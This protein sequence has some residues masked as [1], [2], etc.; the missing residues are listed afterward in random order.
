MSLNVSDFS[1]LFMQ[2]LDPQQKE[3]VR[4]VHYLRSIRIAWKINSTWKGHNKILAFHICIFYFS[5]GDIS[6][7]G[8]KSSRFQFHWW[9][10]LGSDSGTQLHSEAPGN[11]HISEVIVT[12]SKLAL[13]QLIQIQG[14]DWVSD[15][16][17]KIYIYI[18]SLSLW[19]HQLAK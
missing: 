1:L 13:G 10:R 7:V 14:M 19:H 16:I 12:C 4:E 5:Y 18:K 15:K 8:F 2:K 9:A 3:G 17:L 11:L 6:T